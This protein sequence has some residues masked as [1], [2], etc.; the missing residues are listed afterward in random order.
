MVS[1]SLNRIEKVERG[2][3][4]FNEWEWSVTASIPEAGALRGKT[5]KSID[6]AIQQRKTYERQRY[7]LGW[8]GKTHNT[9]FTDELVNRLYVVSDW[10]QAQTLPYKI[11]TGAVGVVMYFNDFEQ[12]KDFVRTVEPFG[13]FVMVKQA[14]LSLPPNTIVLKNPPKYQ[15]RTFFH[16]REMSDKN[17]DVLKSWISG[18]KNDVKPS[19]S[20]NRWLDGR[21][22][23]WSYMQN[24]N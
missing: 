6:H 2:S 11:V 21:V 19:P 9:V 5:R 8:T 13:K 1:S 10:M 7:S 20:M 14:V 3:L 22:R 18:M 16:G 12:A 15:Y 24:L 23:R 4:F 17:K